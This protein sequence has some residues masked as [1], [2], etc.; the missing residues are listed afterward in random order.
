[1]RIQVRQY[2]EALY[3]A[4]CHAD[5]LKR[6]DIVRRFYMRLIRDRNQHYLGRIVEEVEKMHIKTQGLHMVTIA[7]ASPLSSSLKK[8]IHDILGGGTIF[9]EK[10]TPGLLAGLTLLIDGETFIDASAEGQLR[11]LFP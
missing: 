7:S 11:K 5:E 2:A 9:R 6:S 4:L 8:E 3:E 10:I 1:M